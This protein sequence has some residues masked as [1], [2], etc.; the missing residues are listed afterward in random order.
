MDRS[1][2]NSREASDNRRREVLRILEDQ[3]KAGAQASLAASPDSAPEVLYYLATEGDARTRVA[4]AGNLATPAQANKI[5]ASD[6]DEDVRI[7]LARKIARLM[8]TLSPSE[9]GRLCEMTIETLE[10]LAQDQLPRVRTILAEEIKHLSCV[11]KHVVDALARDLEETVA[12]PIVEY[13]PLLSDADLVEIVACA[14]ASHVICAVARRQPLG[15]DV[16]N[17]IVTSLDVP[18]VAAL[19]TNPKAAV[20]Q[21]TLDSIAEHART[22]QA[23]HAPLVMRVD[24]SQRAIR[25]IATFV[26]TALL[27]RLA[28]QH[29][30]DDTTRRKLSRELRH[31]VETEKAVPEDDPAAR[32]MQ[33]VETALKAGRLNDAF[34]ESAADNNQRETVIAALA[35]LAE[36]PA[37][38][39][40]RM[41][42]SHSSKA[43][44]A[45]AW[46]AGLS[47]RV[48]FK[49]QTGLLHLPVSEVLP[50]RAGIYY[51]LSDEEMRW[52]L[53]Y[54][55]VAA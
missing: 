11:P 35:L 39:A 43:V 1:F 3:R 20:R 24:L 5:L 53:D 40:R 42:N 46:R 50:A 44:T 23:W 48:A 36:M 29:A 33:E 31:R 34:I 21:E 2:D 18:A 49:I 26:G 16:S 27:S 54:F 52:H 10:Q 28:K 6:A 38:I 30:L 19:L 47:M 51:P 32:A 4:V 8:P 45:L 12:A 17:A 7:E 15:E 22:V 25:R 13:S 14:Q 9:N 37:A 41:I 55:G